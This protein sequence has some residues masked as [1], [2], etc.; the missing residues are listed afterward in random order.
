MIAHRIFALF[1]LLI[2]PVRTASSL[3][4][5]VYR[6]NCAAIPGLTF[7]LPILNGWGVKGVNSVNQRECEIWLSYPNHLRFEYPP[8]IH[9]SVRDDLNRELGALSPISEMATSPNGFKYQHIADL[10]LYVPGYKP[11]SWDYL[12][13]FVEPSSA[14]RIWILAGDEK[15]G[16]L[17]DK[18]SDK[19]IETFKFTPHPK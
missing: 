11:E 7:E 10:S 16:F 5:T 18:V 14:I 2:L 9:V 4:E 15:S 8:K 19:I 3:E 6:F 1:L 13:F 12:L 17:K